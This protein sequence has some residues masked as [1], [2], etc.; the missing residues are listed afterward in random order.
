MLLTVRFAGY[1]GYGIVTAARLL[2]LAF[3]LQDYHVLQT[4]SH[5]A[6]ARGGACIADLIV[7][8]SP[9]Y[10]LSFTQPDILVVLSRSAFEKCCGAGLAPSRKQLFIESSLLNEPEVRSLLNS[11]KENELPRVYPLAVR[12]VAERLGH[13]RYMGVTSLGALVATNEEINSLILQK[14]VKSDSKLR[15]SAKQNLDAL[16]RG[17]RLVGSR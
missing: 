15:L 3:A 12:Q 16:D 9:I 4:E 10:D 8:S 11:M 6:A 7:S 14:A 17:A 13:V 5:G 1:G 2:G